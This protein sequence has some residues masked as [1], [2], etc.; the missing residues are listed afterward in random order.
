MK[1]MITIVIS[2]G[3]GF[4]DEIP[5]EIIENPLVSRILPLSAGDQTTPFARCE[6]I[7]AADIYSGQ[8]WNEIIYRVATRYLLYVACGDVRPDLRAPERLL[9]IALATGAGMIYAD[10]AE[11][12]NDVISDHPVNDYQEGSIRDDFDFGPLILID[13]EAARHALKKYGAISPCRWAGFYDLRLKIA[14]ECELLHLPE[15]LS[16]IIKSGGEKAGEAKGG[17]SYVDPR[18]SD[19]QRECE[20]AAAAHLKRTGTW[21]SPICKDIPA[22]TQAFP[23][24][25]SVVIPVRNRAKTV[26]DAVKSALAQKTDFPFN[27]IVV[28]NHSTDGTTDILSGLAEQAPQLKLVI[29][30]RFDLS[31]GGCWNE[32]VFSEFCG[33]YA[34]QLDSDDLYGGEDVLQRLVELLRT[35]R[36][37][38]AVGSYTI[39][40]A[41][42]REIPPGLIAHTE[43]SEENGRNNLLRVNGIGAPRAFD[44]ALLRQIGF[45]NVG[46]GEDYAVALRLSRE[47]RVGRIYKSLY[48]CR[49]WEG[50]TDSVLTVEQVNRYNAYKDRLRTIEIKARQ[51][52]NRKEAAFD[53]K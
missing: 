37:A 21:L 42:L 8:V 5:N 14:E 2:R 47:Y 16:I 11:L 6:T 19:F 35:E 15:R 49:R 53:G 17:F 25:A 20:A 23:V 34:V 52:M 3:R 40:D 4:R 44:T 41:D 22:S 26:S 12:E 29:P 36:C 50:N 28:D 18:N 32:A 33:R 10:Y 1:D 24:E 51:T 13:I 45:P 38:L 30:G 7:P 48:L 46:Y 43:W 31:I 27:V 9:S 39:V